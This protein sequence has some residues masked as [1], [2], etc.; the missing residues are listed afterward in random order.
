[1][2]RALIASAPWKA[3]LGYLLEQFR[4]AEVRYDTSCAARDQGIKLALRA[5]ID[6]PYDMAGCESPLTR[7]TV[8]TLRFRRRRKKAADD[9]AD[10]YAVQIEIP[11]RGS[12][13]V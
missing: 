1:M 9:D 5:V 13:L 6:Y 4:L 2:A 10:G 11:M 7:K 8:E 3:Y 12:G